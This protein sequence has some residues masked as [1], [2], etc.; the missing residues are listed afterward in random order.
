MLADEVGE[1]LVDLDD[2]LPRAGPGDRD[3]AGEREC[4]AAEVDDVERRAGFRGQVEDVTH[5]PDVLE[6]QV[7]RVVEVD[8]RLRGVVDQQHPG[9]VAVGVGEQLGGAAGDGGRARGKPH[10]PRGDAPAGV[11]PAV[12]NRCWVVT[13]SSCMS[14]GLRG[15]AVPRGRRTGDA[16]TTSRSDRGDRR[17]AHGDLA[18]P[19]PPRRADQ[20]PALLRRAPRRPPPTAAAGRTSTA[21][22]RPPTRR[23][24]RGGTRAP[25]ARARCGGSAPWAAARRGRTASAM[26][27]TR[28]ARR[29]RE[30]AVVV[31][32]DPGR[33]PSPLVAGALDDQP[34]RRQAG[35]HGVPRPGRRRLV[36]LPEHV[37]RPHEH[38]LQAGQLEAAQP[39]VH[40][41][42]VAV[43]RR[44]P[45]PGPG[46]SPGR[47]PRGRS[48]SGPSRSTSS[49]VVTADDAVAEVDDER[50][51]RVAQPGH[52]RGEQP[53]V[54]PAQPVGVGRARGSAGPARGP[55]RRPAAAACAAAAADS[56]A[57]RLCSPSASLTGPEGS[58]G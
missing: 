25:A 7:R 31:Q 32:R 6:L 15:R 43:G 12:P 41:R 39:E 30:R 3:V 14:A 49:S 48:T 8:V 45:R 33:A 28:A 36:V 46:R 2:A 23:R 47:R 53:A 24:T 9:A 44:P 27:A 17:P 18:V 55:G 34:A 35:P 38:R 26:S 29:Q 37:E 58:P 20:R 57:R 11:A 10:R 56:D 4:A 52:L 50:P 42:R 1:R 54:H 22:R 5:A 51:R 40:P 16:P 13:P 19:P 21:R